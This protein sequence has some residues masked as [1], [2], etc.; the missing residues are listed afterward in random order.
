M[1]FDEDLSGSGLY[2]VVRALLRVNACTTLKV[3]EMCNWAETSVG[4]NAVHL[5]RDYSLQAELSNSKHVMLH[6]IQLLFQAGQKNM[7]RHF[8]LPIRNIGLMILSMD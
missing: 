5:I 6:F 1:T 3:G 8:C 7:V 4:G 2:G